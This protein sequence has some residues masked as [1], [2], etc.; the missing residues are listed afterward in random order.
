MHQLFSPCWVSHTQL[1]RIKNSEALALEMMQRHF[2]VSLLKV[3]PTA[4]GG[5]S[6][7]DPSSIFIKTVSEPPARN[8]ATPIGALPSAKMFTMADIIIIFH[9]F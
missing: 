9:F 5:M 1:K 8:L 7:G 3:S 6:R 2:L 4:I